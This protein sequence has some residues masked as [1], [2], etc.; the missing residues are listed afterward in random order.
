MGFLDLGD[1]AD[2]GH[3]LVESVLLLVRQLLLRPEMLDEHGQCVRYAAKLS[4]VAA[5]LGKDLFLDVRIA[6][7]PE[8][9][10]DHSVLIVHRA[11]ERG[12]DRLID[13][14]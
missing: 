1:L 12:P 4:S 10:V 7:L 6:R 3:E 13:A 11:H 8:V 14:S 5:H 9:D 2:H